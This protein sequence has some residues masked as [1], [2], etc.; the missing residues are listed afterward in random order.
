MLENHISFSCSS[1]GSE[2]CRKMEENTSS[3]SQPALNELIPGMVLG[4]CHPDSHAE[5]VPHN[6]GQR[7]PFT[8]CNRFWHLFRLFFAC[9]C[10]FLGRFTFS[11]CLQKQTKNNKKRSQTLKGTQL[12]PKVK[13]Q[14]VSCEMQNVF[15]R[16]HVHSRS[17]ERWLAQGE[18][19]RLY[20]RT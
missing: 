10:D 13:R 6:I 4:E 5:Q 1:Q 16:H 19:S 20:N 2:Y 3:V 9:F 15:T 7:K 12:K 18:T 14:Q 17:G 8:W 11:H